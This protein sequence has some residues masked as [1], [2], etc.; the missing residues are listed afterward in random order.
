M[1]TSIGVSIFIEVIMEATSEK[2][3]ASAGHVWKELF[4][5]EFIHE[6]IGKYPCRTHISVSYHGDCGRF[7]VPHCMRLG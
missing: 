1:C 5:D 3:L 6:S 7:G 2:Y 4:D